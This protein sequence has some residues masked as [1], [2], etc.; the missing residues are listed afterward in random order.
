[1]ATLLRPPLV[2]ASHRRKPIGTPDVPQRP[3]T[4]IPQPAIPKFL[5]LTDSAP[6]AKF[7]NTLDRFPNLLVTTLAIVPPD[8]TNVPIVQ[9][10]G[11][12][13]QRTPRLSQDSYPNLLTTT[14]APLPSFGLPL[15]SEILDE[16]APIR[17]FRVSVDA[18]PNLSVTT[19]A[20]P[21]ATYALPLSAEL[22]DDSSPPRKAQVFA[23]QLDVR[24][25]WRDPVPGFVQWNDSAPWVKYRPQV[26]VYP[27]ITVLGINPNAVPLQ[28]N[29]SAPP[30][31]RPVYVDVFPNTTLLLTQIIVPDVR[32]ETQAQAQSD[33]SQ[34]AVVVQNAYSDTVALGLVI[35]QSL[36]PGTSVTAGALIFIVV[37]LGPAPAPPAQDETFSGGFFVAF[38][39]EQ[40]RRRKR[41]KELDEAEEA[42]KEIQEALDREIAQ[43]LHQQEREDERRA[44]LDR[45]KG[46][47]AKF[48]RIDD[49]TNERV[50]K[51]FARARAQ[52]NVSAYLAL[53]RELQR[54]AEEE[55]FAILMLLLDA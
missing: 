55:E 50:V 2:F 37:S 51:A 8:T 54:A 36:D 45:L 30:P 25:I 32:G 38:E 15:R 28:L 35:S 27:N 12:A 14:L 29:D 41:Q 48:D 7:R 39:R 20:P 1:V 26:D 24:P 6:C 3:L 21:A 47:V 5:Q 4:L 40:A 31:K 53:E 19:L 18:Y 16:S 22:L 44:E 43:L 49:D 46:L 13:P 9:V 42:A 11:S 10:Y 33:L 23:Q 17:R 52:A 34:F